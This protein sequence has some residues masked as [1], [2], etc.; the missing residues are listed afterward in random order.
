MQVHLQIRKANL[1][2][3]LP[4]INDWLK[5]WNMTVLPDWFYPEDV[6]IIPG[7]I[8]ASYYKTNSKVAYVE[9][10][11]SNPDCPRHIVKEGLVLI[12]E[13]ICSLAK[14]DGYLMCLGWSA[15]NQIYKAAKEQNWM[16]TDKEYSC[17]IKSL[18]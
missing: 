11:V 2:K 6:F 9:Q 8:T 18:V 5:D 14:S 4:T 16:I 12:T 13:H 1:I 3:D 7:V 10:I 17:V 15:N